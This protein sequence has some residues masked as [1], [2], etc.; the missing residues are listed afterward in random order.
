MLHLPSS[1]SPS[2]ASISCMVF[3]P[4][5]L[6]TVHTL[7]HDSLSPSCPPCFSWV[8]LR[9]SLFLCLHK[10]A[11]FVCIVVYL[12]AEAELH[13]LK[14][15]HHRSGPIADF[16]QASLLLCN[17]T[18]YLPSPSKKA[19][20]EWDKLPTMT[21]VCFSSYFDACSIPT[22]ILKHSHCH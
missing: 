3:M 8:N 13:S 15:C 20:T 19:R 10:C 1:Y 18:P 2:V 5:F 12:Y 11:T 7:V 21:S 9:R 14:A 6:C 22:P 16:C 4:H 17:T